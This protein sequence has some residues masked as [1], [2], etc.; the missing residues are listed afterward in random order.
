M[1]AGE[2][3]GPGGE[4]MGAALPRGC[5]DGEL[6]LLALA[7]LVGIRT[8]ALLGGVEAKIGGDLGMEGIG[9]KG[10]VREEVR[11]LAMGVFARGAS[12]ISGLSD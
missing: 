1:R 3:L 9:I 10:L 2:S 5:F 8:A 12:E 4:P 11:G 7:A 6:A